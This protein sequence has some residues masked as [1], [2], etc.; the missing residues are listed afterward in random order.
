MKKL[1]SLGLFCLLFIFACSTNTKNKPTELPLQ[2]SEPIQ[3]KI[4][5]YLRSIQEVI[6]RQ[7]FLEDD[8][9]G[10][11]CEVRIKMSRNGKINDMQAEGYQ[12]LCDAAVKAIQ[13]AEIP[14]PPDDETY[15]SFKA[16]IMS[17]EPI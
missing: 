11:T 4:T 7:L 8:F 14:V 5:L 9:R 16:S 6:Q 12:P 3:S 17:F 13:N 1:L 10:K 15:E 2:K